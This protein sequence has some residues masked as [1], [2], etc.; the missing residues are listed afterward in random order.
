M[1]VRA[2]LL[3]HRLDDSLWVDPLVDVQRDGRYFKARVFGFA[4]PDELRVKMGIVLILLLL[5]G[6]LIRF[7]SD[8]AHRWVVQPLFVP[9]VILLE[10]LL[11]LLRAFGH[12]IFLCALLLLFPAAEAEGFFGFGFGWRH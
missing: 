6:L 12:R 8:Q 4:R 11:G 10:G 2:V 7:R 5:A 3:S 9:V 1:L